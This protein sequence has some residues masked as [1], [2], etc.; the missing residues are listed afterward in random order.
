MLT[1][2][3]DYESSDF[4]I[5]YEFFHKRIKP[6]LVQ[7]IPAFECLKVSLSELYVFKCSSNSEILVQGKYRF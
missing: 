2:E 7:R 3:D 4:E 6:N 1:Q 5:D